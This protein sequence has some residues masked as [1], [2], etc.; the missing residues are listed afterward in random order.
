M[1][2]FQV[3][4]TKTDY[5]KVT[6]QNVFR[7]FW[8]LYILLPLFVLNI[9][10]SGYTYSFNAIFL[11]KILLPEIILSGLIIF[12]LSLSFKKNTKK[13]FKTLPIFTE[14]IIYSVDENGL[15]IKGETFKNT[16]AWNKFS[17]LWAKGDYL[18]FYQTSSFGNIIPK[19]NLTAEQLDTLLQYARIANLKIK[20]IK[21]V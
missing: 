15:H 1:I 4:V 8:G 14:K 10:Y 9:L 20:G 6:I 2:Q 5:K 13:I 12:L 21:Q 3:T 17:Y 19:R 18:V 16:M 11:F 7:Q